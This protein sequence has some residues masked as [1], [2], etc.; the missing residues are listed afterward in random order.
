MS[1]AACGHGTTRGGM[2]L[3]NS[4][5]IKKNACEVCGKPLDPAVGDHELPPHT[6]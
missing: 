3:C 1:N 2:Q 6:D 4:C 5:A